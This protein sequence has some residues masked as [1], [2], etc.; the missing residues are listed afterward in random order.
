MP[1]APP[2]PASEPVRHG[3]P[4][5][6]VFTDAGRRVDQLHVQA[7]IG[8]HDVYDAGPNMFLKRLYVVMHRVAVRFARLSRVQAIEEVFEL[9]GEVQTFVALQEHGIRGR[10]GNHRLPRTAVTFGHEVALW[11]RGQRNHR[12]LA[13]GAPLAWDPS[14]DRRTQ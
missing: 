9:A 13:D 5:A 3:R 12:P 11:I 2:G 4:G 14:F 6:G 7:R 1:A 8:Q 10:G